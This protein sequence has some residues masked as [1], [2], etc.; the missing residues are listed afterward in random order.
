MRLIST[1]T[2]RVVLG[3]LPDQP[4]IN[5]LIDTAIELANSPLERLLQTSF[6]RRS[7]EDFFYIEIDADQTKS[8]V[9]TKLRLSQGFVDGDLAI[10]LKTRDLYDGSFSDGEEYAYSYFT[11]SENGL[12]T[13]PKSLYGWI[14]VSYTAGF[15]DD[16]AGC[17]GVYAGVPDWLQTSALVFISA[18]YTR[19]VFRKATEGLDEKAQ[20]Y[21]SGSLVDLPAGFAESLSDHIRW[22]PTAYNSVLTI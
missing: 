2:V 4:D 13:I 5:R 10:S 3:E 12:I 14:S 18:I 8:V 21:S 9:P 15:M 20:K 17:S 22:Y 7:A 16:Q 19:L 11:N 1:E 6:R